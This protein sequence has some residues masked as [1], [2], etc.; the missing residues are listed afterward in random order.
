MVKFKG[1]SALKQY[2]PLKPIKRG[3]KVWER[4]DSQSGYVYDMN[5]YCGKEVDTPDSTLGQGLGERVVKTLCKSI[6]DPEVM[7]C[8]DRFFASVSLM[9]SIKFAAVST[10][11]PKRKNLPKFEDFVDKQNMKKGDSCSLFSNVGVA[12]YLWKDSKEV[13]VLS[14]CHSSEMETVERRQ[15]DGTKATM[16]CPKAIKD[17]NSYMGGVDLSDQLSGLYDI[18]RKSQKWWR[19]VFYKL[20]LTSATNAWI[21]FKEAHNRD[22]PFIV[23]LVNLAESLINLGRENAGMVRKR[24]TSRPS[25]SSRNMV[26][27]GDHL[28]IQGTTRRR[29]HSCSS[30]KIEKRTKTMCSGC[31]VPLCADC[32]SI[33][34][35]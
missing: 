33:Y 25:S 32:F 11:M 9:S 20:F 31:K 27:V 10:C 18:D 19:K 34:H 26:N 1:R 2:L 3:I 21:L 12:A 8:F 7:V 4:C 13:I 28:P 5:I 6:R 24:C 23:F 35:K 17:Y 30:K 29:C 16:P 22:V 14:N 15:K